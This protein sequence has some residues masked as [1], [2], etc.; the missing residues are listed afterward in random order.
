[1]GASPYFGVGL[2]VAG[3]ALGVA[4]GTDP[5]ITLLD[6]VVYGRGSSEVCA[7]MEVGRE[8]FEAVIRDGSPLL[9]ASLTALL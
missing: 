5:C 4:D 3:F 8:D 7:L 1:L 2:P 6:V 9:A